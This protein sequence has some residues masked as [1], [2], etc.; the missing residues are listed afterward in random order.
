MTCRDAIAM[1]ADY[2]EAALTPRHLIGLEEHLREC[3][4]CQVYL[5]TYRKTR[6]LAARAGR[7]EMPAALKARLRVFLVGDLHDSG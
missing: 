2:L 1:L 7:V 4:E 5:A 3:D 6:D